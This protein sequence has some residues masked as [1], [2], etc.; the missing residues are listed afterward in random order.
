M[1]E[2]WTEIF[3]SLEDFEAS[4]IAE[5]LKSCGIDVVIKSNR[6]TPYPVNIG[7]LGET[8]IFVK[9]EEEELAKEI[10]K[11]DYLIIENPEDE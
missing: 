6:L 9:K 4:M 7:K 3:V 10:I 1:E 11:S 5:L 8:R 2:N